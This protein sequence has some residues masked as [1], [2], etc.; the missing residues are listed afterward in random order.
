MLITNTLAEGVLTATTV[1]S[2]TSGTAAYEFDS[3]LEYLNCNS[4]TTV[5]TYSTDLKR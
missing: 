3:L 5:A 1:S 2:N 4:A